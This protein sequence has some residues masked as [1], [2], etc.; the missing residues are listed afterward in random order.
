MTIESTCYIAIGSNI[1]PRRKYINI[2]IQEL[3]KIGTICKVAKIYKSPPWGNLNQS[4]FLNTCV[5]LQTELAPV[6]LLNSLKAIELQIGRKKREHWGARE[7]DLDIIF[8]ADQCIDQTDLKVPHP[9]FA[10]R[11]FVL[12][13]LADLIPDYRPPMM[14]QTIA[15]LNEASEDRIMEFYN[16]QIMAIVNLTPDSF[17]KDGI[18]TA[19]EKTII[20]HCRNLISAG[21]DILDFGAES[22]RPGATV[23]SAEEE[24]VRLLPVL[25]IIRQEFPHVTISV[26]SYK[27]DTILKS[28]EYH[29]QIINCVEDITNFPEVLEAAKA[30]SCRIV[31]M[32]NKLNSAVSQD[33]IIGGY[34]SKS[35]SAQIIAEIMQFFESRLKKLEALNFPLDHVCLDPGFGFGKT[36]QEN[37]KILKNVAVFKEFNLPV[38]AA[39]SNKS[40]LGA[41]T[42]TTVDNRL[43][44]NLAVCAKLYSDK[45]DIIRVHD[46]QSHRHFLNTI[47]ELK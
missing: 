37:L 27:P 33:S 30:Q 6:Q 3:Q 25:K 44:A 19:D 21:A 26:D 38:L 9:Y 5:E 20:E 15:E 28:L 46:I 1:Y 47:H 7:I 14:T 36:I 23:V 39:Y 40:F 41:L 34:Y 17:S 31:L 4:E 29:P 12:Q 13:P 16:P 22:T 8:Y 24:Q 42:N 32:H 43:P 18:V 35:S 2:A 45:I 10:E 11:K